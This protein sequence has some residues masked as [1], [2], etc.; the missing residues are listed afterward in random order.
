MDSNVFGLGTHQLQAIDDFLRSTNFGSDHTQRVADL[1]AS[2]SN[3]DTSKTATILNDALQSFGALYPLALILE[4]EDVVKSVYADAGIDDAV[5]DTTLRDV[6]LWVDQYASQHNGAIGLDRVFWI[7]RHLCAI[8]LH[9]GRLQFEPKAFGYPYQIFQDSKDDTMIIVAGGG[10]SCDED[11]YLTEDQNAA[12][13]TTLLKDANHFS[14][15]LVDPVQGRIEIQTTQLNLQDY[16]LIVDS[17]T[18]VLHLHIPSG[19]PLTP[20]SID[21]S[22]AMANTYFPLISFIV[23][24]SWLLDPALDLV[25]SQES[26]TRDFMHRFKKF[27]VMHDVPQIYERVFGFGMV[28]DDVLSFKATTSLQ[29]MVQQ[30]LKNGVKFHTTGGYLTNLSN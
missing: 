27:P 22:L 24:S 18:I 10:L 21:E 19:S 6:R 4:V 16:R 17:E 8:I 25:T 29:R 11:G 28:E 9:L 14:G 30:A 15:H 20:S 12:F 23:C 5:R 13:Q 7:S 3:R 2:I 26:N 1:T